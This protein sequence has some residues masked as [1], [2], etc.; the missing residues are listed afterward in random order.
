MEWSNPKAKP[1]PSM[2]IL[3]DQHVHTSQMTPRLTSHLSTPTA[4]KQLPTEIYAEIFK[5]LIMSEMTRPGLKA[6]SI[7]LFSDA[8][9][10]LRH[11]AYDTTPLSSVRLSSRLFHDICLPFWCRELVLDRKFP[12]AF[13]ESFLVRETFVKRLVL[14]GWPC[15][16]Y[17]DERYGASKAEMVR[18]HQKT[19]SLV[20]QF[21]H[22]KDVSITASKLSGLLFTHLSNASTVQSFLFA[23]SDVVE[24][25]EY[26]DAAAPI[27]NLTL[28]P[29]LE[30]VLF[31]IPKRTTVYATQN[32]FSRSLVA[33]HLDS[34]SLAQAET[35]GSGQG[36]LT[37]PHLRELVFEDLTG[38]S[39]YPHLT[40]FVQRHLGLECL[41]IS[42][43]KMVDDL[44]DL[45]VFPR[46][47]MNSLRSY[48]G[49][50]CYAK[51]F[52]EEAPLEE[53]TIHSHLATSVHT[54]TA[55]KSGFPSLNTLRVS[56]EWDSELVPF[57][58]R[59]FPLLREL[60]IMVGG[61]G[62]RASVRIFG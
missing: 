40:N 41:R 59:N 14:T 12:I 10:D 54:W 30:S 3:P 26:E 1:P 15:V 13:I 32:L 61:K 7:G 43:N 42:S 37:F 53:L 9:K 55:L 24:D 57:I 6:I 44:L 11:R 29:G 39:P 33:L 36:R 16:C 27:Q 21:N 56:T 52:C 25:V 20:M 23:Q 49:P 35:L 17:N 34:I 62:D 2:I 8:S 51:A 4:D 5:H 60:E 47:P 28:L 46:L 50:A 31:G 18:H 19:E 38:Y 58:V 45:S 48:C 22:I